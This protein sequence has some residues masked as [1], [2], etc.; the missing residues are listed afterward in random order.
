MGES[1]LDRSLY[2]DFNFNE[3]LNSSRLN[4]GAVLE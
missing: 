1:G 2:Q 3:P 4:T